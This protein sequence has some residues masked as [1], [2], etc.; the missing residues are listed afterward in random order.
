M[1]DGRRHRLR[2]AGSSGLARAT[3]DHRHWSRACTQV[4]ELGNLK[5]TAEEERALVAFMGT[6]SDGFPA[7]PAKGTTRR[8]AANPLPV[9]DRVA[10][11]SRAP[12]WQ[13]RE[14]EHGP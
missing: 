8:A 4:K 14:D 13:D 11:V 12:R 5:L 1:L 10:L 2:V 6:L 7:R 9:H 3:G